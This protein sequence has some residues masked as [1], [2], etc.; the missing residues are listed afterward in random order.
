M[1]KRQE[2]REQEKEPERDWTVTPSKEKQDMCN[3]S[4]S[5]QRWKK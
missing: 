2:I 5:T 4:G 1:S 3:S